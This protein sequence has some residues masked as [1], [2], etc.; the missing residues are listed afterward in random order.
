MADYKVIWS[1]PAKRD[2]AK[3]SWYLTYKAFA[4][5]AAIKLIKTIEREGNALTDF[6]HY[7]VI[8]E[9]KGLRRKIITKNYFILF[10]IDENKKIVDIKRVMDA[11]RNWTELKLLR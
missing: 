11:R 3:I 9:K 8:S 1:K 2:L 10:T 4:S 7:T 5:A 6:P